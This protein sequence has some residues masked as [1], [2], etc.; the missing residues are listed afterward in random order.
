M[1]YA[2]AAMMSPPISSDAIDQLITY[3][4]AR[5]P[6][7]ERLRLSGLQFPVAHLRCHATVR[8]HPSASNVG[9]AFEL[10]QEYRR[11]VSSSQVRHGRSRRTRPLPFRRRKV[12]VP[13][14]SRREQSQTP[15]HPIFVPLD[16]PAPVPDSCKRPCQGSHLVLIG[17]S[18]SASAKG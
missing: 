16:V 4:F 9:A 13:S 3:R 10:R 12:C 18:W 1:T 8:F 11:E 6:D 14:T 15:R 2:T 17:S 5:V 7:T